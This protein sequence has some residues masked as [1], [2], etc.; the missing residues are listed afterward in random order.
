[1]SNEVEANDE[2]DPEIIQQ[3]PDGQYYE[4]KRVARGEKEEAPEEPVTNRGW[5]LF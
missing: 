2:S 5:K 4:L 3:W 1:M